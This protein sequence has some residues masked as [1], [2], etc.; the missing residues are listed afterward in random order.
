MYDDWIIES[1]DTPVVR[2]RGLAMVSL[3][4]TVGLEIILE[5]TLH[6]ERRRWRFTFDRV[7]AY[8][9]ID[10]SHRTALWRHRS[11][12]GGGFGNTT[13]V[14]QSPWLAELLRNEYV[15]DEEKLV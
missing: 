4:D 6:P 10:E 5:D 12:L 3:R 14:V 8:L 15:H 2:I 13:F 1:W 9:N 7:F 11:A